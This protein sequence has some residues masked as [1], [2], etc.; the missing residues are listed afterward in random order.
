MAI[1][2]HSEPAPQPA[3]GLSGHF[4]HRRLPPL[5]YVYLTGGGAVALAAAAGV[6]GE[7]EPLALL[8]AGLATLVALIASARFRRPSC[9]WP[10]RPSSPSPPS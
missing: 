9:I 1:A 4:R 8:A 10:W 2:R 6:F 3:R 5:A 7:A